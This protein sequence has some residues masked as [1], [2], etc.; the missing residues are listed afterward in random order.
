[1]NDGTFFTLLPHPQA[2]SLLPT[3]QLKGRVVRDSGSLLISYA[4]H[5]RLDE[6][7]LPE[8][9]VAPSRQQQLWQQTCFE[10][11]AGPAGLCQYWEINLSPS[12]DWNV[13]AFNQYRTGMR[14]ETAVAALPFSI[15]QHAEA[16]QLELVFPLDALLPPTQPVEL[17]AS[18]VL[19]HRNGQLSYWAMTHCGPKPDFHHRENFIFCLS[20]AVA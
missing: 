8:R 9:S 5:G 19:Q 3:V 12:G 18:A 6:L 2:A 11:F 17:A 16:F 7:L 10:F 13:Y 15:K 1:M 14:E 20:A 4:V